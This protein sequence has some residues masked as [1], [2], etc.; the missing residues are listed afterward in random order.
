MRLREGKEGEK[1]GDREERERGIRGVEAQG[2]DHLLKAPP[3][4]A[5]TLEV[6]K[7]TSELQVA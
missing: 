2:P 6:R 5:I 3:P 7:S 1:A 4:N